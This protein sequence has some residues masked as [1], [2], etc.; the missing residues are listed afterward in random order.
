LNDTLKAHEKLP[1]ERELASALGVSR[2]TLREALRAL[3]VLGV[4]DIRQGGGVFVSSLST[5]IL[6]APLNFFFRLEPQRLDALFEARSVVESGITGLAA[7][8]A[9]EEGLER[10]KDCVARGHKSLDNPDDFLTVDVEFHG[11][12]VRAAASPFLERVAESLYALGHASREITVQVPGVVHQSHA[13]HEDI[14]RAL[15]V[16]DAERASEAMQRHLKNV[17]EAYH[18]HKDTMKDRQIR[19]I[20]SAGSDGQPGS[21]GRRREE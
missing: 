1:S 4:L 18:R 8:R 17:Q 13:D 3:S 16:R 10:L 21:S 5:E 15:V 6:L 12:I 14:L 9:G 11:L 7:G 19:E 20:S 2:P